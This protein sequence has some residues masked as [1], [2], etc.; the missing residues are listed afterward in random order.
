MQFSELLCYQ[1]TIRSP[2]E[3]GQ[4]PGDSLSYFGYYFMNLHVS[5]TSDETLSIWKMVLSLDPTPS[6]PPFF[7][8]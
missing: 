4:Y 8:P 7:L 2:E 6:P 1:E 5:V 3:E